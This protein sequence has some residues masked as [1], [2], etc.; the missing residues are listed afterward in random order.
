MLNKKEV[1]TIKKYLKRTWSSFFVGF[2][3]L[4]PIQ[5]ITIPIVLA[6]KNAI[7]VSST[8]SGKTEAVVAPLCERVLKENM[9]GLV[10]LY[11]IP[12]KALAN[13]LYDR[14]CEQISALDLTIAI[15]TGDKPQFK[16][17]KPPNILIT[18]PE[19]LDS[20]ICR[21]PQALNSIKA[22]VLD[23]I[24]ILDGTYRGD[25]L[26][27][28]LKR[29]RNISNDFSTYALS[30]TVASPEVMGRRYMDNFEVIN[31]GGSREIRETYVSSLEE[32]FKTSKEENLRK[33]LFFCNTRNQTETLAIYAKE[34]WGSNQVAVHHGSLSKSERKETELFLKKSKY[35][36]CIS[37]MT[38][39]IG[40][41]IGNI[42]A[43]V[44]VDL[45]WDVSS[46]VQ[47]IGRAGRRTGVMRLFM[48]CD[49]VNEQAFKEMLSLAKNN[50]MENDFYAEDLSV[51]V[52]QIFSVLFANRNGITEDYLC[53]LFEDFCIIEDLRSII[54]ELA[55]NEHIVRKAGKI[56]ASENVLNLGE[57][58]IIHSNIANTKSVE[59][60]NINTND[61]V[62]EI[63]LSDK[64][65]KDGKTF[66]LA[67]KMWTIDKIKRNLVYVKASSSKPSASALFKLRITQGSFFE[68]LPQD[69]QAI[70]QNKFEKSLISK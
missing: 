30:A 67:G 6:E 66:V 1:F 39:E 33:I 48:L 61:K 70:Q 55:G 12:T 56:Y 58:G 47:R 9:E 10:I 26:R 40:I 53:A 46:F 69:L 8:A 62:G 35:A 51:V 2:G 27:I 20:L 5:E 68:Y 19:S 36:I 64:D 31:S 11:I 65:L 42:D 59:V 29:L 50:I 37:T 45:P 17:K 18:T 21:Y 15:K 52:Q 13:D 32:I 54:S 28:L 24:H 14:L 49:S 4:L 38:L 3:G 41:D 44:L 23:E 7:I 60:I 43:V 63:Y 25:Q 57:R 22:V 34:I 16:E